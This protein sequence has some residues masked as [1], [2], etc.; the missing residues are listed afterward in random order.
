MEVDSKPEEIDELD[1]RIIQLKIERE[2]L[3]KE[4]R[5]GVSKERLTKLEKELAEPGGEIGEL[6]ERWEAEKG[7]ACR[8]AEV[9]LKEEAGQARIEAEQ[10][11]RDGDFAKAGE[12]PTASSP[13]SKPNSLQAADGRTRKPNACSMRK[14]AIEDIAAVVSR[15][16]GIPVDKMLE[17]EREKLL[18]MEE[19][20]ARTRD[21][22]GRG[23]RPPSPMR[24]A[25]RARGCRIRTGRS[26]RSCS[27]GPPAS[28]R[29]S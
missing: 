26:A 10:A 16:T 7:Q 1:R 18:A 6:T 29:Q 5:Q 3:K 27:W 21:R 12:L 24:F 22:P 19:N 25:G 8:M 28:A 13:I 14:C 11:Q 9:W 4:I 2:A 15:W 17:G 23:D 20:P